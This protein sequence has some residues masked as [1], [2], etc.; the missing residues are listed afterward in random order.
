MTLPI[1]LPIKKFNIEWLNEMS[2]NPSIREIAR[3][4]SGISWVTREQCQPYI[5]KEINK[6]K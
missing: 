4:G 6:S 1:T 3:R 5:T 2:A